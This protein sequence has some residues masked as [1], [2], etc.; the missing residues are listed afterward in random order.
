MLSPHNGKR[1]YFA[2]QKLFRSDDRGNSWTAVS[3]DLTRKIDRSRLKI[4]DKVWSV[5]AV[6]RNTSTSFFGNIVAPRRRPA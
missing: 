5:D 4:M 3:P 1:L 2:A 6:A